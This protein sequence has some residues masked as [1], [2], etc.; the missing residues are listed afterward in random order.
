[1]SQT[2][3]AN[4][5]QVVF[6]PIYPAEDLMNVKYLNKRYLK[7]GGS[8]MNGS[9]SS[10]TCVIVLLLVVALAASARSDP[11]GFLVAWGDT[12]YGLCDIPS[13]DS[14]FV[15]VAAGSRHA[16]AIR[17]GGVVVGWGYDG[18][19]Q[20]TPTGLNE[21]FAVVDGGECH[22]VGTRDA[23]SLYWLECWGCNGLGQAFHSG[24]GFVDVRAG[25]HHSVGLLS[26]GT[27]VAWGDNALNQLA[28]PSPNTDFVAVA[29]GAFHS[30]ALKADGSVVCWGHN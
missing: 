16:L 18:M 23:A 21:H 24:M 14:T 26:G 4:F 1:M 2:F 28:I 27:V 17:E 29:A 9:R 19:G 22:S 25:W 20:C 7:N 12:S 8:A 6:Q 11:H 3:T 13:A 10:F 30:V 5:L 15:A